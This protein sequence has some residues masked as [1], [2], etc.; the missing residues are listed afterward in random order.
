MLRFAMYIMDNKKYLSQHGFFNSKK[1]MPY[2]LWERN[3]SAGISF[4]ER[5]LRGIRW[6]YG[7]L[8]IGFWLHVYCYFLMCLQPIGLF[9]A[10]T[11]LNFL[12]ILTSLK[13]D[14]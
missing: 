4:W 2:L 12:I 1:V 13:M 14:R 10:D 11:Q 9:E 6:L 5:N 8:L 3:P 7:W